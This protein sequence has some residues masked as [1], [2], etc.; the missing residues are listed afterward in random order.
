ML[1]IR[2]MSANTEGEIFSALR[3]ERVEF[4]SRRGTLLVGDLQRAGPTLGPTLVLCHGMESTRQ[5]TKQQA[6]AERF[7]P[8]GFS[9]LRFD[10]SYVGESEGRFEDLTLSGEVEDALGAIDF[11][12]EFS[13]GKT[14]L[15][16]S[17]LGGAVALLTAARA[18][19]R[20]HAVATIA[21]VADT[22]LFTAS[23]SPAD[24]ADW[25]RSGRRRWREGF[26]NSTFLEDVERL[27]IPAA[28]LRA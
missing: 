7:L 14:V 11:L 27:D 21:A 3:P 4:P 10:F 2:A 8:L 13:P 18:P 20:V 23:L 12:Q 5:G 26:L 17:S 1:S 24:I 6:M 19:E 28:I 25:R 9:L 16:G 22:A 15:I